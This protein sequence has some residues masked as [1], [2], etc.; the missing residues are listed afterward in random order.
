[1]TT[2]RHILLIA[3]LMILP[4]LLIGFGG[5]LYLAA[6]EEI[7]LDRWPWWGPPE[8]PDVYSTCSGHVYERLRERG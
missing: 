6:G 8:N 4:L 2:E 1:V 7:C 3:L 5:Y